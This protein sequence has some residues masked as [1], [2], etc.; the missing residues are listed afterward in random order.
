MA[1]GRVTEGDPS[2]IHL[3][4]DGGFA[5]DLG[6]AGRFAEAQFTHTLFERSLA[7]Q[8][9]HSS[10]HPKGHLAQRQV[11]W[12]EILFHVGEESTETQFHCQQGLGDGGP[13]K[14]APDWVRLIIS[15]SQRVFS[16][17]G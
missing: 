4:D 6:D 17:R 10:N 2:A 13:K 5:G 7:Q 11:S 16:L 8:F 12:F 15:D 1:G 3:A 14:R 9:T